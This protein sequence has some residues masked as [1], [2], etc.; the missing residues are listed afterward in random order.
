MTSAQARH[1]R[2]ASDALALL[3]REPD[4]TRTR[5]GKHLGLASGPTSD[6]VKR[7]ARARLVDERRAPSAGP[8][9]PTT[10]VRAHPSGPVALVVDLR[11]GDW[12]IGVCDL[13][14]VVEVVAGGGRDGVA[15]EALL[16][17]LRARIT[18]LAERLGD[19]VVG[20]GV[21]VPGP[22]ADDRLPT[23]VLGLRDVPVDRIAP[24]GLPA[25]LGNDA[26]AAAVAE[27]RLHTPRPR[28][29]LH[30]VVEVG[31]GGAL[32]VDGLPAP[33]ARG[34]HGEFGHLPLGDPGVECPCGARGCWSAGFEAGAVA[35]RAGL[36]VTG[37]PRAWLRDFYADRGPASPARAGLAADLGRGIAGLVNAL[38]PDLVTLGGLAASVRDA[39]AESFERAVLAGL[40]AVHRE[41]PPVVVAA[42]SDED[43]PLIGIGLSVFDRVLDADLLARWSTGVTGGA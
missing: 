19:R 24:P 14:G 23:T 10:T 40:M 31:I 3:R 11:H 33:S 25:V 8:G 7:L 1:W 6:L 42:R 34:L 22:V 21:A 32:L 36:T 4:V 37:D 41:S 12:R 2:S 26:T 9:R 35:R 43:A 39:C 13:A 30:V 16:T 38:D 28:T 29:L 15:P 17:G 20:I 27:A 5:L 18:D